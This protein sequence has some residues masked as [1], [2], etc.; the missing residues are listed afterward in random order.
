MCTSHSVMYVYFIYRA[1][2]HVLPFSLPAV[3]AVSYLDH[4]SVDSVIEN[5]LSIDDY[6]TSHLAE[7]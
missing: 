7:I 6:V 5:L 4:Q 2:R 3:C 1:Q